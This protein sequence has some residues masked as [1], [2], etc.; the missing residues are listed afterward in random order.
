MRSDDPRDLFAMVE[1]QKSGNAADT[2]PL[3]RHL[4][5][6]ARTRRGPLALS[7]SIGPCFSDRP[8]G[9]RCCWV[10]AA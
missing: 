6:Q 1:K 8:T 2:K 4:R 10:A 3:S 7:P 5:G 9:R